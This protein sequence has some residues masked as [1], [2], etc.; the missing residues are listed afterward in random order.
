MIGTQYVQPDKRV[1]AIMAGVIMIGVAWR[2]SMVQGLGLLVVA[3]LYP[4]GTV[5]GNT[6]FA[7]ILVLLV[8]WFVRMA[9]RQADTPRRTPL[10]F[11]IGGLLLAFIVSFY[12]VEPGNFSLAFQNFQIVIA[13]MLTFY[14]IVNNLKT[15]QDLMR[16][17]VF[18]T[19]ALTTACLLS[20]YELVHGGTLIP[21]WISFSAGETSFATRNVRVG[22]PFFD[23]E[24]MSEFCALNLLLVGFLWLRATTVSRK[25]LL[26]GVFVLTAFIL[27]A[28]VTRGSIMALGAG[29]L[30][31]LWVLRR[32]LRLVPLV[33]V[34]ALA[35]ASFL[36]MNFYVA[37]FTRSGDL[38]ARLGETKFY[39]GIPD[40]RIGAWTVAWE[41][42]L[43]HPIIGHGPLY[44]HHTGI[45]IWYWPHNVYLYIANLVGVVGLSFF[46]LLLWKLVRISW[47]RQDDLRDPNYARAFLTVAHVQLVVFAI[48]ELKI[49]FL[50][51]LIYQF[52]PWILFAS[53]VAAHRIA[54]QESA[55]PPAPR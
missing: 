2:M 18:Q 44:S 14:L 50:R 7:L 1:L 16:F 43:Q 23:F 38:L 6:N 29:V 30:Y 35:I 20:V 51:N 13:G 22:G 31:G 27:F 32:R 40:S 39:G 33:V 36:A 11:A 53:I 9:V 49:D 45:K 41:R 48:D 24:L 10:D 25:V 47:P 34:T 3:L 37:N 28:T 21:G 5:F 12:N 54:N 26:A 42:F 15:N 8:L 55:P 19:I 4:R 17:H 52:Q 46:L